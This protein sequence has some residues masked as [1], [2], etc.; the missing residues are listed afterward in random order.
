MDNEKIITDSQRNF[1]YF[2]EFLENFD[3]LRNVCTT[4]DFNIAN[5]AIDRLMRDV[6]DC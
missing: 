2:S 5:E 3:G 6:E 1:D 4:D